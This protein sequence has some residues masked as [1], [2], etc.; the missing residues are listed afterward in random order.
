MMEICVYVGINSVIGKIKTLS[1]N[2]IS[3]CRDRARTTV[4][5]AAGF[6]FLLH[7]QQLA[8]LHTTLQVCE[9]SATESIV[10][11]VGFAAGVGT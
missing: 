8:L 5:H 4:E 7:F 1:Y 10:I 11:S 2:Y 9:S 3:I 6:R